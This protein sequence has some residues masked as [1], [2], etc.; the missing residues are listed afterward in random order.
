MWLIAAISAYFLLAIVS[1]F[2]RY[3]LVGPMASPKAY[4][5]YIGISCLAFC[6]VFIPFGI[7]L[8]SFSVVLLGLSAGLVRM[9]G[10]LILT[11]SITKSEVSRAIPAIGALQPIFSF[12]LF[13]LL[14][15]QSRPLTLLQALS[16]L[17]LIFGSILISSKKK[18][19]EPFDLKSLKYPILAA[20]L[21]SVTFFLIKSLFLKAEEV[22]FI[23]GM[24]LILFGNGLASLIFLFFPKS[25]KEIFSQKMPGKVSGFF[26]LG[27][28]LGG[29]ALLSQYYAVF[30][31]DPGQVPLI[32]A[33]EGTRYAFLLLFVFLLSGW[34]PQLLKEEF[35]RETFLPK[36][37][38]VAMIALG[39]AFLVI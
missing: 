27:Q 17:L 23:N 28:A 38:A 32:N 25:R 4:T 33:L 3:F 26:I 8:P 10:T 39:M 22:N 35:S 21:Y 34:K 37:L 2:D 7:A 14:I 13:F 36:V 20:F 31:A 24:F 15:P 1:L 19:N 18:K 30:L 5:F 29:L 16:F 11:I 6:L 12:F 9:L